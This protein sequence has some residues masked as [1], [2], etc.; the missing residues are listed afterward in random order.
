MTNAQRNNKT[1]PRTK[2]AYFFFSFE[3]RTHVINV[4][5]KILISKPW[6]FGRTV[7]RRVQMIESKNHV[8]IHSGKVK[9]CNGITNGTSPN[10]VAC[11]CAQLKV[12]PL[13]FPRNR[14][15]TTWQLLWDSKENAKGRPA[16]ST[17]RLSTGGYP[18]H[19]AAGAKRGRGVQPPPLQGT[20]S[21]S[22]ER[23]RQLSKVTKLARGSFS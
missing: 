8:W 5:V 22:P 19:V 15:L 21:W 16:H 12:T 6:L 23:L 20:S 17:P 3:I 4:L 2:A 18:K 1:S 7:A 11:A 10:K 13:S 14:F 9:P